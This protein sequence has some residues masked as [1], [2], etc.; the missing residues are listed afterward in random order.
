ML[1][2]MRRSAMWSA[3]FR[4]LYWVLIIG[5]SVGAYVYVQPYL[6][7]LAKQFDSVKSALGSLNGGGSG[8][9]E[10]GQ[11]VKNAPK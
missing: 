7:L 3:A 11:L 4:V 9:A 10:I 5:I 8:A 6:D 2:K 1:A